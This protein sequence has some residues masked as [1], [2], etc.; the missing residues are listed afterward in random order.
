MLLRHHQLTRSQS[1]V[2]KT[3]GEHRLDYDGNHLWKSH[4][5]TNIYQLST[6]LPHKI[7]QKPWIFHHKIRIFAR[8]IKDVYPRFSGGSSLTI[9]ALKQ[10]CLTDLTVSFS[11]RLV[12]IK[13]TC[14][15]TSVMFPRASCRG[16]FV[17]SLLR[18]VSGSVPPGVHRLTTL[19][20]QVHV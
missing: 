1:E 15:V 12:G 17:P 8:I 9:M 11:L 7:I 4:L 10:T 3:T 2:S 18:H 20:T 14:S 5:P 19:W 13:R 6:I 16:R